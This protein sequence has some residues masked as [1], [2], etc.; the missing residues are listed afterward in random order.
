MTSERLPAQLW[1]MAHV[2]RC[3]A[4]GTPAMVVKKG[5][6]KGGTLILK[7]NKLDGTARILTQA[8]DMDG[9]V[10]WLAALGEEPVEEAKADAYIDR[11]TAR[12]P[13]QWVVEVEDPTGTNPFEGKVI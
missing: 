10:A 12:D 13:D 9:Q 3:F 5:D 8:T 7:I 6:P 11:S 2:R 4:S 1:I